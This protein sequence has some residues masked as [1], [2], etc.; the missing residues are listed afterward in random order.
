MV[1]A[2]PPIPPRV[3]IRCCPTKAEHIVKVAGGE[4][5]LQR[6]KTTLTKSFKF[7]HVHDTASGNG[8]VRVSRI[9]ESSWAPCV[10]TCATNKT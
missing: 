8:Y 6:P 2:A 4:L 10:F 9:R 1:F 5:S 7:A 3:A